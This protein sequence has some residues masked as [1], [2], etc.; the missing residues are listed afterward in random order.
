[1]G[2]TAWAAAHRP[3]RARTIA[4]VAASAPAVQAPPSIAPPAIEVPAAERPAL[5]PTLPQAEKPASAAA[6]GSPEQVA[7]C[8]EAFAQRSWSAIASTCAAAFEAR[9]QDG[10]LAMRVAQAEHRRGHVASAADWARKAL[11]VDPAIPEAFVIVARAEVAAGH[12][13]AGA[14]AYQRYLA[15]APRGWHASEARR[16][17]R[18]AR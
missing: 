13:R 9:P 11:A 15:L 1:M 8:D 7:P 12:A 17:L 5:A 2:V 6:T 4:A 18:A 16:A 10:A 14:D 3:A